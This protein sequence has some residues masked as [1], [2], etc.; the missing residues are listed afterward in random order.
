M[1]TDEHFL[2]LALTESEAAK[3]TR[4]K[5][6]ALLVKRNRVFALGRNGTP[7]GETD[8]TAGGCPR[9]KLSYDEQPA[10]EGYAGSAC[11]HAEMNALLYADRADTENATL[12]CTHKPCDDC[13][14]HI[15]AAG[16][17]RI[18]APDFTW[19]R[20]PTES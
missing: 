9:G 10:R 16:V 17:D 15:R 11:I 5:V 1:N 3:C 13:F 7:S 8:C 19:E 12:Y 2:K 4:R 6:G 20:T 18:V 14:K